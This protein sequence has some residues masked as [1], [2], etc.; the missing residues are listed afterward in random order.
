MGGSAASPAANFM[1][2][3]INT[4]HAGFSIV[5]IMVVVAIIGLLATLAIPNYLR[6]RKRSQAT[7]VLEDLR[8]IDSAVDQYSLEFHRVGGSDVE[9]A[10]IQK[11]LKDASRLY[12]SSGADIFGHAFTIPSVDDVPK[13]SAATFAA[14]LTSPPRH[15]GRHTSNLIQI[16]RSDC[17]NAGAES[18]SSFNYAATCSPSCKCRPNPE[19]GFARMPGNGR[20]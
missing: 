6:S 10:D 17:A 2:R 5:E 15:S 19:E 3:K 18:G 16:T 9:W 20:P 12:G 13:V 7:Q 1:H 4:S 14:L 8:L 11:Y